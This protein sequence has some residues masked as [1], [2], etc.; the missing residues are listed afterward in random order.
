M[1]FGDGKGTGMKCMMRGVD[2]D[3][4][5]SPCHSTTELQLLL[6]VQYFSVQ[7]SV[8]QRLLVIFTVILHSNIHI[9]LCSVQICW[10]TE[11]VECI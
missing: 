10:W 3:E 4:L 5:L 6:Q 8:E 2:E 1:I 7:I 11:L 9:L